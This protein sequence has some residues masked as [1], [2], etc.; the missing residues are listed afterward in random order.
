MRGHGRAGD[1]RCSWLVSRHILRRHTSRRK[2]IC[3]PA[4]GCPPGKTSDPGRR[5]DWGS[6]GGAGSCLPG[7]MSAGVRGPSGQVRKVVEARGGRKTS[8]DLGSESHEAI[9]V[10]TEAGGRPGATGGCCCYRAPPGRTQAQ[11][12][13]VRGTPR[14]PGHHPLP[15]PPTCCSGERAGWVGGG[16]EVTP[17]RSVPLP[18]PHGRPGAE[19]RS[20]VT[21]RP[22]GTR[23]CACGQ[24]CGPAGDPSR[25]AR[26][27]AGTLGEGLAAAPGRFFRKVL[28]ELKLDLCPDRSSSGR[29]RAQSASAP[30]F[31]GKIIGEAG[32]A[33][34]P[35]SLR[36]AMTAAGAPRPDGRSLPLWGSGT[37]APPGRRPSVTAVGS[38]PRARDGP[39]GLGEQPQNV[40]SPARGCE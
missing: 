2:S 30:G 34:Q 20:Q 1:T 36:P 15:S 22:Q 29:K 18:A 38:S 5:Q 19:V 32:R 10:R 13:W 14:L 23:C 31:P 16:T 8:P 21:G 39:P 7:D 33:A 24:G 6:G 4:P 9:Q 3:L 12:R 27:P 35:R 25:G 40:G 26:R 11:H 37:A 17:Q 28:T